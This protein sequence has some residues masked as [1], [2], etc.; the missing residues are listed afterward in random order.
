M[1]RPAVLGLG[2]PGRLL[3]RPGGEKSKCHGHGGRPNGNKSLETLWPA[4]TPGLFWG[5]P[6]DRTAQGPVLCRFWAPRTV[7][8][9]PES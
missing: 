3:G 6:I 5:Y 7:G 8:L 4:P 2:L 1:T 9:G